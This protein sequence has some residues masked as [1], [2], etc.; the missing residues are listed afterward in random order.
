[1]LGKR[2]TV[3]REIDLI[4]ADQAQ[5]I[6][7]ARSNG[8]PLPIDGTGLGV[9]HRVAVSKNANPTFQTV[10]K[11][12]MGHPVCQNVVGLPRNQHPHIHATAD[13]L[14]E[15]IDEHMIGDEVGGGEQNRVLCFVDGRNV[16]IANRKRRSHGFILADGQERVELVRIPLRDALVD[17]TEAIPE[18]DECSRECRCSRAAYS[19]MRVTP[20]CGI[21]RTQVVAADEADGAIHDEQSC[22]DP[23]HT[24][25]GP[26]GARDDECH[27]IPAHGWP[28]E[29]T[30]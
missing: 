24:D 5:A 4:V 26:A 16:E 22:D 10:R 1:M 28:D 19:Q 11:V 30:T 25:P 9:Q 8:R 7:I 21:Q 3:D 27:D 29:R 13:R 6:Q 15:G 18:P 2:C 17:G 12:A 20:L 23:G 14:L